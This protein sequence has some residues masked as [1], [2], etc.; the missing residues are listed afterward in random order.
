MRLDRGRA[1]AAGSKSEPVTDV[2]GGA[3][4]GPA[5]SATKTEKRISLEVLQLGKNEFRIVSA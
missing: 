3:F 2:I 4:H 5:G 1:Q